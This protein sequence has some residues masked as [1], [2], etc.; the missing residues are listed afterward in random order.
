ML[1]RN[2]KILIFI[3][4]WI[5]LFQSAL[6]RITFNPNRTVILIRHAEKPLT[7]NDLSERGW[8]RAECIKELFTKNETI[9]PKR[10]YAQR[11]ASVKELAHNISELDPSIN[12]VLVSWNH[13]DMRK[14]L[15]YFGMDY[16][17]APEYPKNRYDLVW[18]YNE[19]N[20][21]SFFSQN[22][23]GLGDYRFTRY[24]YRDGL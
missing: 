6:S 5:N 4:V 24:K 2:P 7:G 12:P 16:R 20:E 9:T 1:F 8:L 11:A 19:K 14:F 15:I 22:C 23:T 3:L 17:I 10:I 21:F 18:M 13:E